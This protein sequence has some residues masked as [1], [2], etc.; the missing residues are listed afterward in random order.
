MN[1]FQSLLVTFIFICATAIVSSGQDEKEAESQTIA[2]SPPSPIEG[3]WETVSASG[4]ITEFKIFHEGFFSLIRQ[5]A[6]GKWSVSGAGSY[7]LDGKTYKETFRYC[8][9]PTI[10]LFRQ[11]SFSHT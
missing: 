11:N 6:A 8:S 4:K 9:I 2:A 7:S 3:A 5:D 1:H 10:I